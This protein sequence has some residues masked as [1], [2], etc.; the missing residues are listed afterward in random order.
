MKNKLNFMLVIILIIWFL[1]FATDMVCV[2]IGSK[3]I[4]MIPVYG[5]EIVEY[6][7]LGYRVDCFFPLTT[8]DDPVQSF[9]EIRLAPYAFI[10]AAIVSFILIRVIRQRRGRHDRK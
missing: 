9:S 5:G 10:N 2:R 7:G 3:P 1:A 8:A 4:F 6:R